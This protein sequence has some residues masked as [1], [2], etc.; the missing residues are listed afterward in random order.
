M[1][2]LLLSIF[3]HDHFFYSIFLKFLLLFSTVW[4]TFL[5]SQIV[6][7]SIARVKTVINQTQVQQLRLH[8]KG[9]KFKP[10]DLRLYQF[11]LFWKNLFV[12]SH[13]NFSGKRRLVPSENKWQSLSAASKLHGKKRSWLIFREESMPSRLSFSYFGHQ[14]IKFFP[15]N[16]L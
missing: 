10:T 6:R 5:N 16:V 4:L 8:F 7:K 15:P 2:V 12:Y 13:K 3:I 1:W 9:K 11:F 14:I